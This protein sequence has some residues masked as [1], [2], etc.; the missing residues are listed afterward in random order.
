MTK[1]LVLA[2][3]EKAAALEA[4]DQLQRHLDG[5]CSMLHTVEVRQDNVDEPLDV[6]DALGGRP[7]RVVVVGGDGTLLAQA[8]RII[9]LGVPLIGVNV[10]RLGFLADFSVDDLDRFA[11]QLFGSGEPSVLERMMLEVSVSPGG[12]RP[13]DQACP[14]GCLALND[15]AVVAG[16]PFRMIEL[17]CLLDGTAGPTVRGDGLIVSSPTGSTGYALSAGGPIV[18][19][20]VHAMVVTPLAA[21]SL[22]FRPLVVPPDSVINLDVVEANRAD[23]ASCT[24]STLVLDGQ[25]QLPI[26]VG[27]RIAVRR[28]P[29]DL[30]LVRHPERTFWDTLSAKMFW[31]RMPGVHPK[32]R[33]S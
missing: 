12:D 9:D 29:K 27:D 21:H 8:R 6:S 23:S 4:A 18:A 20:D 3:A 7:D 25:V 13:L 28:Y 22:S 17:S 11:E 19:P 15:A 30:R 14:S 5:S 26:Y 33:L 24:G 16:P 2:N 1:V 10:G 32:E 31:A